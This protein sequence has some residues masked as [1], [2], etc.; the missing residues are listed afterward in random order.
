[1]AGCLCVIARMEERE[2]RFDIF[3]PSNTKAPLNSSANTR[4]QHG[5]VDVKDKGRI[6]GLVFKL[7]KYYAQPR[8]YLNCSLKL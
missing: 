5:E 1:M 7:K 6:N 4:S 3:L 8:H 2:V